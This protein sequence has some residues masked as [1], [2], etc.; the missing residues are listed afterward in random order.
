MKED[1]SNMRERCAGCGGASGLEPRIPG[2][3][4]TRWCSAC[5]DL[6]AD[7]AYQPPPLFDCV[8][9]DDGEP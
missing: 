3:A 8:A 7:C 5:M 1:E 4:G 6:A 9:E 2:D